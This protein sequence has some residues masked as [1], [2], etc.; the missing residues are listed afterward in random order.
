MPSSNFTTTTCGNSTTVTAGQLLT[1]PTMTASNNWSNPSNW[2]SGTTSSAS[3]L[4]TNGSPTLTSSFNNNSYRYSKDGE[5]RICPETGESSIYLSDYNEWIECDILELKKTKDKD[6]NTKNIVSVSFP[7]SV[8]RLKNKQ[9]ER[10]VLIEKVNKYIINTGA[11]NDYVLTG[12]IN[13]TATLDYVNSITLSNPITYITNPATYLANPYIN[14]IG[15]T[16]PY[17][18]NRTNTI[19]LASTGIAGITGTN[20]IK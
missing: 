2:I 18:I 13:T 14:Y 5:V 12:F 11:I 8:V 4:V 10:M 3:S 16:D 9:K 6:G 1:N 20:Q 15:G 19:T 17:L 7:L